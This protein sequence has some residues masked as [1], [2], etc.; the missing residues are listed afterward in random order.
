MNAD[1]AL[2]ASVRDL[3]LAFAA[4][5]R[6]VRAAF[7]QLAAAE[8]RV[9][10]V[11]LP[12]E[13]FRTI[14]VSA[15]GTSYRDDF[16]NADQA[17][18]IMAR[19]AWTAIVQRLELRR[20]MS[21]KAWKELEDQL[22]GNSHPVVKLPPIT[23][24]NVLRFAH[25]H[26]ARARGYLKD[27]VDE[28]FDF[29]RPRKWTRAGQ[30]KTNTQLEIGERV[31]LDGPISLSGYR[32]TPFKVSYHY[33]QNLLA[34]ENVFNGLAG[35]GEIAKGYRSALE[36]AIAASADGTG[37]TDLFAFKAHKNG[38]L[39]LRFKRLDLL[40]RFNALAGGK[41]LRPAESGEDLR[42]Q[43]EKARAENERL[44]REAA[45]RAGTEIA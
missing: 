37:E 11:F 5:E 15:C 30:L 29:L 1:L 13:T 9:N 35:N 12:N 38:S 22:D 3:V 39:H 23:E 45:V 18:A 2:R 19:A 26:L 21:I 7:A 44:K 40:E 27:A 14:R 24:E 41:N 25:D 8:E 36:N 10:A 31:I 43:V 17:V 28:V 20:F 34:L 6:D 4:A 42:R 16:K 33:S 32:D